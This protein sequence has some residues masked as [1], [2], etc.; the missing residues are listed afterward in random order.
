MRE[1]L[2]AKSYKTLNETA[3][4]AYLKRISDDRKANLA[5]SLL[6][7]IEKTIIERSELVRKNVISC[8]DFF[9]GPYMY[10]QFQSHAETGHTFLNSCK[11]I[12][13]DMDVEF[14]L[15][16]EGIA[17]LYIDKEQFLLRINKLN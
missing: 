9:N 4:T 16:P 2:S 11:D 8:V 5:T 15:A 17:A 14:E 7:V 1:Y 13:R 3:K 10:V 6:S 12:L